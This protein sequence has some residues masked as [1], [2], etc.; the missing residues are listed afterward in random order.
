MSTDRQEYSTQ[1]QTATIIAYA[2]QHNLQIVRK[3]ADEGRSGLRIE[4]RDALQRLIQ[5][6]QSGQADFRIVLVYD[7]SRW[8][9][10]QD[11][12]EGAYYEFVCKRA[13]IQV[14][15]CAEQFEN[16]G[17]LFSTMFKNMKRAMAAEF[18]RELSAKVFAGQCNLVRRGF[19]QGA[20]PGYGLRREL[21]DV[22]G[23]P[24]AIL[25]HGEYKNIQSDRVIL[26]PGPPHE[27]ETVRRIFQ[28]FVAERKTTLE[29][30]RELNGEGVTNGHGRLWTWSSIRNILTGEKYIGTNVYNRKSGKLKGK[31]VKNA[32]CLWIRTENAFQAIVEPSLFA[33]ARQ[34]NEW[35]CDEL[36]DEEMLR[37][38]GALLREK[39]R[40]TRKIINEAHGLPH[41]SLYCRR[42]GS[43]G[44]AYERVGY[45]SR[46]CGNFDYLEIKRSLA[47]RFARIV[48]EVITEVE[49]AGLSAVFDKET[50][51]F[52][53]NGRL[54][55][56]L[57][58]VR[59]RH[60][61]DRSPQWLPQ[62]R[63]GFPSEQIAAVGI[64]QA[65][66][67]PMDYFLLPT[68]DVHTNRLNLGTSP[69][70]TYRVQSLDALVEAICQVL[71]AKSKSQD[72]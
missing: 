10:F 52:V 63:R 35:H 22:N 41:A 44:Q 58:V 13:G 11:A 19:W 29:I 66:L 47:D 45:R 56:A 16:D 8:G 64:D 57:F 72:H 1:N 9:R 7:V 49:R 61:R 23:A 69:L 28:S 12:D 48:A 42:F 15:Y 30:A 37:L 71:A 27:V 21:I 53:I 2:E 38:L 20:R 67:E 26:V 24:K 6:V 25:A 68:K 46:Y 62:S 51:A 4:G 17:S 3:Y 33:A 59:C 14:L 5:D 40:L 65:N 70:N 54:T 32:P 36:P 31:F 39:G 18:S 50:R 34:I 43:I 60:Y 55:V